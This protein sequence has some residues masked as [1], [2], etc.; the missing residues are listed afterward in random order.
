M[1]KTRTFIFLF[2]LTYA[3]TG[4]AQQLPLYTMLEQVRPALN[5][6]YAGDE[7]IS[8]LVLL[9]RQQ[10]VGFEGAP[11]SYYLAGHAPLRNHQSGLGFDFQRM[12]SGPFTQNGL[13]LSYSYT[14][15]ISERSTIAFGLRGGFNSYRILY[16]QLNVLEPG[17]P[18]FE[19]DLNHRV[20]PN[21]GTGV[22]FTYADYFLDFSIPL[23][24]RN[25]FSPGKDQKEG[26]DNREDRTFYLLSGYSLNLA[27]GISLHPSFGLWWMAGAP[28]LMDLRIFAKVKESLGL[29]MAYRVSGAFSAYLTYRIIDR[30]TLGY[31]YELPL[32]Y[33]YRLTSATHEVV[34]GID[35]DF[36]KS[37]TL[38]PRGF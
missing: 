10:W 28:P 13:F 19:T 38:S 20:F 11:V 24:L 4:W 16:S 31:A 17:D 21:C 7:E 25:E 30:F 18:L 12:N 22:H 35:F 8:D 6:A 9:S 5:P 27:K 29:G 33:D 32:S 1:N 26:L 23:L 36:L 15:N 37:K 34:L 3:V 14:V 2:F